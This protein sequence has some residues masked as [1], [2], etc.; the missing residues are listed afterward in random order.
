[1]VNKQVAIIMGSKSDMPIMQH[2]IDV[3]K[4]FGVGYDVKV[5]SAHRTPKQTIKFASTA[6]TKGI[7]TVENNESTPPNAFVSI[8]T[9]ITGS[10]VCAAIT[11]AK[12]AAPP[13]AAI[14][15]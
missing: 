15:T 6:S 9:P 7:C 4:A 13:A 2:G 8:G 12:C 5:L 11:P 14:I 3:L 1:M 10:V